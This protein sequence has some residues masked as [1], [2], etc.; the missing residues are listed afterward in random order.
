M[1][2]RCFTH[3]DGALDVSCMES[4]ANTI[5]DILNEITGMAP[6]MN[7]V[8]LLE[9]EDENTGQEQLNPSTDHVFQLLFTNL[10]DDSEIDY[11]DMKLKIQNAVLAHDVDIMSRRVTVDSTYYIHETGI[12][13]Q[14]GT[15]QRTD[16][17]Q[18]TETVDVSGITVVVRGPNTQLYDV[19]MQYIHRMVCY[20]FYDD[21]TLSQN[22]TFTGGMVHR[23]HLQITQRKVVDTTS[24]TSNTQA[25]M[26]SQKLYGAI[27]FSTKK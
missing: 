17:I 2:L 18:Y 5:D 7:N 6:D 15:K 20:Y 26:S 21:C 24:R 14:Y 22:K 1:D 11:D 12:A 23:T 3:D 19:D 27:T 13:G 10:L 16:T 25:D 4:T 9:L 8:R